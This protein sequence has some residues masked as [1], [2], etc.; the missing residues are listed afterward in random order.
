MSDNVLRLG[1]EKA[2]E[3]LKEDRVD[4]GVA[5]L[6]ALVREY[7]ESGVVQSRL[8][9]AL[10]QRNPRLPKW[11]FDLPENQIRGAVISPDGKR[12]VV[13]RIRGVFEMFDIESG[14]SLA[15]YDRAASFCADLT[16]GPRGEWVI[17]LT[18]GRVRG[19]RERMSETSQ[20]KARILILSAMDLTEVMNPIETDGVGRVARISPDRT[21]LAASI[22][23]TKIWSIPD[24]KLLMRRRREGLNFIKWSPDS[25]KFAAINSEQRGYII[26]RDGRQPA[27]IAIGKESKA[28]NKNAMTGMGLRF[29]HVDRAGWAYAR[30][31][32]ERVA[33]L[34]PGGTL[35]FWRSDTGQRHASSSSRSEILSFA[36]TGPL[37]AVGERNGE[38]NL[39]RMSEVHRSRLLARLS[40]PVGELQFTPDGSRLLA[41]M[42][43]KT[44]GIA[45]LIDM[46]NGRVLGAGFRWHGMLVRNRELTRA[47]TLL[48][49]R[50]FGVFDLTQEL[51]PQ[52]EQII[53]SKFTV[54][55]WF[56]SPNEKQFAALLDSGDRAAWI[57]DRS[58]KKETT[59]IDKARKVIFHPDGKLALLPQNKQAVLLNKGEITQ[60]ENVTA[61]Y[62]D[63]GTADSAF[64]RVRRA[65]HDHLQLVVGDETIR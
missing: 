14:Q 6:A 12:M 27:G 30:Q 58:S 52:K 63:F 40:G 32:A 38:I 23:G 21:R 19:A 55:D 53:R 4:A 65:G 60:L 51:P 31:S 42:R 18:C 54:T 24:G 61:K 28:I 45:D 41:S 5:S 33:L 34:G 57:F 50:K 48:D 43:D 9:G 11:I 62:R 64:V 15:V 1:I 20:F 10:T 59:R 35:D 44:G 47:A 36:S 29:W 22:S 2:Q 8:I 49:N 46:E 56:I 25:K 17:A 16:Y 3:L 7:P 13:A 26:D 37:I 39:R